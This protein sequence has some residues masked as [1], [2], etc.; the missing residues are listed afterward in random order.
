MNSDKMS[1]AKLYVYLAKNNK[2]MNIVKDLISRGSNYKL[3]LF[4][5]K[6]SLNFNV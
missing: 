4:F 5:K 1:I 6:N 2:L 3:L